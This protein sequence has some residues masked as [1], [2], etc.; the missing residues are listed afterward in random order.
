MPHDFGPWSRPNR[1]GGGIL[2]ATASFL[3][4]TLA[5][6]KRSPGYF[7]KPCRRTFSDRNGPYTHRAARACPDAATVLELQPI[8]RGRIAPPTGHAAADQRAE[9]PESVAGRGPCDPR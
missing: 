6:A 5:A 4:W 1:A 2:V 7:R 9:R 3:M 8:V